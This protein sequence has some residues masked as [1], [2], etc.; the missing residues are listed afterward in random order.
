MKIVA[1]IYCLSMSL[2]KWCLFLYFIFSK[3]YR[4]NARM[5]TRHSVCKVSI[6]GLCCCRTSNEVRKELDCLRL[7]TDSTDIQYCVRSNKVSTESLHISI[8][9]T[10]FEEITDRRFVFVPGGSSYYLILGTFK[11]SPIKPNSLRTM[12]FALKTINYWVKCLWNLD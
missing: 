9:I 5:F 6:L 11:Y 4:H 3:G 12:S 7:P 2:H 10:F 1:E 8:D